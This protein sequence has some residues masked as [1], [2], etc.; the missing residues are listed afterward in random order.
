MKTLTAFVLLAI[1][2]LASC[3]KRIVISEP[4]PPTRAE[5]DEELRKTAGHRAEDCR[6][7]A[8]RVIQQ[9]LTIENSKLSAKSGNLTPEAPA[10][11]AKELKSFES[12][13]PKE[14]A[15]FEEAMAK[16]R[17]A[18]EMA[19]MAGHYSEPL[20]NYCK[21]GSDQTREWKDR[22][23]TRGT[24]EGNLGAL[25]NIKIQRMDLEDI[26]AKKYPKPVGY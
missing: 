11:I 8:L 13:L 9:V 14:E 1:L 6:Q 18:E 12:Q 7:A 26:V 5:H 17:E 3:R 22:E 16:L 15:K 21:K 10:I 19:G 23:A 24:K 4:A 2:P 20:A 25:E